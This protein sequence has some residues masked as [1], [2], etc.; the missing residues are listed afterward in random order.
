MTLRVGLGSASLVLLCFLLAACGGGGSSSNP[1]PSPV[2][3]P[4]SPPPPP[5]PPPG[6]TDADLEAAS[7][8]AAKA[9]FGMPYQGI[10]DIAK[11]GHEAWLDQQLEMPFSSHLEFADELV[12]RRDAGEF[13]PAD[14]GILLTITFWRGTWWNRAMTAPDQLRQR[15]AY[16]L[17]QIFVVSDIDVLR[18]NPPA[19]TSYM[20][21]L[22]KGTTGN[23]RDLLLDV[24]LHPAM[25]IYLSHLNN[26]KAD[27]E[28]NTYPDEN[29]AREIMQLFSIGLFELNED[30]SYQ[31]DGDGELIPTY[32]NDDIR[33]YAKVFTGLS[34]GG[35]NE[36]F[37]SR[38]VHFRN[39]M[40]MF[41]H[42][43]EPSAKSLLGGV[44]V[45]EGQSGMDDI[46]MAVDSL[47]NHPNVGPFI[48]RQ[49]IQRLTTSNPSP[50]YISRVTS[51]FNG[52][53]TGVR[54]DMKAVLKAILL[55]PEVM[56]PVNP[57]AS[58]RMKEPTLRLAALARQFNA[59]TDDGMFYNNGYRLNYFG[60][61]HPLNA[62]S[63][64]NFYSPFHSPAGTLTENSLVAPEFQIATST[65]VIGMVNQIDVAIFTDDQLFSPSEPFTTTKLNLDEYVAMVDDLDVLLGRLNLVMTHGKLDEATRLRIKGSLTTIPENDKLARVQHAIYLMSISPPFVVET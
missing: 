62:P 61:Q 11:T 22:G 5:P 40:K 37:G 55:D 35:N 36:R 21:M 20:D 41:E 33:E 64:F 19:L 15:A 12:R 45:P 1:G 8:F 23:F 24:S 14:D 32:D 53:Q 58:G 31:L 34:Y 49:L 38:R 50:E 16:A 29:Y 39:P 59:E 9:T 47:F 52:D 7:L 2:V 44:V 65:T 54:G 51:A 10:V 26:R 4:I 42:E 18:D 57:A 28:T 3:Q 63:V 25:G 43:H 56:N 13:K 17:S 6:P 46:E 27:P 30:G 48:G 60:E